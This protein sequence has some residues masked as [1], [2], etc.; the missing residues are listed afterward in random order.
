MR[1]KRG[2]RKLSKELSVACT[3]SG[4]KQELK[5]ASSG[6]TSIGFVA[7]MAQTVH[8]AYHTDHDGTWET[9]PKDLCA[10]ARLWMKE[11]GT[12]LEMVQSNLEKLEDM[13]RTH[14]KALRLLF[15]GLREITHI[16]NDRRVIDKVDSLVERLSIIQKFESLS[17]AERTAARLRFDSLED[18]SKSLEEKK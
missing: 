15:D 8:Q 12:K 7:W 17:E 5:L 16:A 14:R 2:A 9:C 10:S 1:S 3:K 11:T 18:W 4:K 6:D 13:N